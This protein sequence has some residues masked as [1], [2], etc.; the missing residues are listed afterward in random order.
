MVESWPTCMVHVCSSI[1]L[2]TPH[3]LEFFCVG[4]D[5][6]VG[7][8]VGCNFWLPISICRIWVSR[9]LV[10]G[11]GTIALNCFFSVSFGMNEDLAKTVVWVVVF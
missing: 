8:A 10:W 9:G 4:D 1:C 7:I 6:T 5:V 3:G 2:E 11:E